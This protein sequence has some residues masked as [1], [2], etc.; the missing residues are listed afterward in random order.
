MLIEYRESLQALEPTL[1]FVTSTKAQGAVPGWWIDLVSKSDADERVAYALSYWK[2]VAEKYLPLSLETLIERMFDVAIVEVDGLFYLLYGVG[3]SANEAI[4]YL[5]GNPENLVGRSP[6]DLGWKSM[7]EGMEDFYT[8]LHDGFFEFG[9]YRMGPLSVSMMPKIANEVGVF[10]SGS[11][12][13]V[14][15]D[16]ATA[17]DFDVADEDRNKAK[18]HL[19]WAEPE[20]IDF[21]TVIDQWLQ[22]GLAES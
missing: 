16:P 7:P 11:G 8:N 5:G 2:V 1:K 22:I 10:S 6:A 3:R 21:W 9:Q 17:H 20:L 15:V 12:A 13:Y 19:H 4:F 14:S 18:L